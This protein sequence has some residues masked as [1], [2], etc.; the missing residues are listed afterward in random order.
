MPESVWTAP[1]IRRLS[2]ASILALC[3]AVA[4]SGLGGPRPSQTLRE[5]DFPA[6]YAAAVIVDQGLG[7]RLY[8]SDLQR[9]IQNRHW[10]DLEGGHHY[11]AYPPYVAVL[12]S[13]LA[14]YD[15]SRAKL[16]FTVAMLS[17][18]V[19]SVLL[20]ARSAPLLTRRPIASAAVVATFLPVT[21]AVLGGQNVSLSMLLYAGAM[22]SLFRE[23]PRGEYACGLFLG[24]WLFKPQYALLLIFL[25]LV[26]GAFRIVGAGALVGAFY[27]LLGAWS[28]GLLWPGEWWSRMRPFAEQDFL[29]N[30]YQMIS[31][32]G[33]SR[34]AGGVVGRGGDAERILAVTGTAL[35]LGLLVWLAALFWKAGRLRDVQM[36]RVELMRLLDLAGPA[37]ILI[38][39]HTLYY[40]IGLCVFPV[41]RYLKL[42]SDR[43]ITAFV[44]LLFLIALASAYKDLFPVQP[45]FLVVVGCLLFISVKS[46]QGNDVGMG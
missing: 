32:V 26:A 28:S 46:L 31:I 41:A 1:R 6:F 40:D 13:P 21:T 15:A 9:S 33:V 22:R 25:F 16:I 4:I 37:L 19:L 35:T 24:L 5:G 42:E 38:S 10:P 45:L 27:Y 44:A 7:N 3:A 2:V 14:H 30:R 23:G 11:F 43:S 18:L 17:F 12:L 34:A 20:T 39:P 8:D 29:V 36:R